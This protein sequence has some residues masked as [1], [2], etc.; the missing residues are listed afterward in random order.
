MAFLRFGCVALI[1]VLLTGCISVRVDNLEVDDRIHASNRATGFL[2]M[3]TRAAGENRPAVLYV[4]ADYNPSRE[5]PLIVFL[6]G[7]GERGDD[8]VRQSQVGIGTAIR[9]NPDRFQCLVFM[10][11][12]P[13]GDWWSAIPGRGGDESGHAHITDGIEQIL[14]RYSIDEDRVSLTGLSMGGFGTFSY[15]AQHADRFSAFMPICGGGDVAGAAQLATKPMWVL[16][17]EADSVVPVARS[18]EM[19]NAIREEGGSVKFTKYPGVN[20][21]SWD[22]AYGKSEAA[23]EWLLAQER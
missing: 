12:C 15:G 19:V 18:E 21:N 22:K 11:Q 3:E 13:A 14:S 8:G 9:Q 16:H 20:H 7:A 1:G 17:G 23:V 6:H 4:P 2:D 10:P 5:Y